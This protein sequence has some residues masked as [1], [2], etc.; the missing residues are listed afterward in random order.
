[1]PAP[2][3]EVSR[4]R[5]AFGTHYPPDFELTPGTPAAMEDH[6]WRT[7]LRAHATTI[8]DVLCGAAPAAG[9]SQPNTR[10]TGRWMGRMSKS[11]DRKLPARS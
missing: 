10:T 5:K 3:I 2:M 9:T 7:F 4:L 11:A 1:M 8:L 6:R